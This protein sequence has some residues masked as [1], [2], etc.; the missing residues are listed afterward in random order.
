MDPELAVA[1]VN[2]GFV[3]R[4]SCG[5]RSVQIMAEI[6]SLILQPIDN[7]FEP[8]MRVMAGPS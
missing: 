8:L 2:L 7:G 4:E 3:L 5:G 1:W 6:R